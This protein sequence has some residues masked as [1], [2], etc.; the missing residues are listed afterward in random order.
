MKVLSVYDVL[1]ADPLKGM[2]IFDAIHLDNADKVYPVLHMLGI[3]INE[4]V[5]IYSAYHRTLTG[6]KKVGYL[7]AGEI[8]CD[9]EFIKGPYAFQDDYLVSAFTHD[10]GLYEELHTINTRCNLYGSDDALDENIV[11]RDDPEYK[12]E[13]LKIV[14]QIKQLDELLKHIRGEQTNPDGSYK[15][16][17]EYTTPK[18]A[19]KLRKKYKKRKSKEGSVD[20]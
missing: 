17:E 6:E 13:E 7:F 14:E 9:R 8:R 2:N 3:N 20:E 16:L 15:T 12:E 5:H 11:V 19:E 10:R 1:L 4:P 18:P